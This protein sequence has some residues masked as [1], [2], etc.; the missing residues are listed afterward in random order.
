[1]SAYI[2]EFSPELEPDAPRP[3]V[4]TNDPLLLDDLLRLAAVAGAELEVAGDPWAVRRSWRNASLVLV[5]SDCASEVARRELPRRPATIL[6]GR[7]P[8]DGSV[9]QLALA[10]GAE[11]V[12]ILPDCEGWLGERLA[13]AAEGPRAAGR[14]VC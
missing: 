12:A 9:W 1:M 4:L 7:D 8:D 2:P 11:Q 3:L 5:G 6:V 10:V 13:D 14:T